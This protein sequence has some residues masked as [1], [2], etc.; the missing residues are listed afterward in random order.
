MKINEILAKYTAGEATLEETNA[1]LKKADANFHLDPMKNIL[2]A[3]E[4]DEKKEAVCS[5]G[6]TCCCCCK[7][8]C[9]VRKALRCPY[10]WMTVAGIAG[11]AFFLMKKR[12]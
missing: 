4:V 5:T 2:T 8:E 7:K 1:A 11:A 10:F 3:E 6:K 9:P 12:N